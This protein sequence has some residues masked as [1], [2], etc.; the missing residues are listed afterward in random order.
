[1]DQVK[2]TFGAATFTAHWESELSPKT[3]T[4]FRALLPYTQKI[5]HARWS[6]EACW[7]P[8]GEFDL[9]VT[10]ENLTSRPLPGQLD[11][12]GR[13]ISVRDYTVRA[14]AGPSLHSQ[15]RRAAL[16][17]AAAFFGGLSVIT[18]VGRAA[19]SRFSWNSG[20]V[21]ESNSDSSALV[22]PPIAV[23]SLHPGASR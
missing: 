4:A 18:S 2:I 15:R 8:L 5:I 13:N 3:C 1:M 22:Q 9:G 21:I 16:P 6:G 19:A 11:P 17:R 20:F 14:G 7:I 23:A 12:R 10:P